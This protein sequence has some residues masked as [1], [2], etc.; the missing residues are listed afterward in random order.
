M[1]KQSKKEKEVIDKFKRDTE[2]MSSSQIIEYM[3]LSEIEK[4]KFINKFRT[5]H[6]IRLPITHENHIDKKDKK[7]STD[8][9]SN[10]KPKERE[11]GFRAERIWIKGNDASMLHMIITIIV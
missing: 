5:D 10:L 8:K 3:K 2:G 1:R 7:L 11:K 4:E 6:G 9:N